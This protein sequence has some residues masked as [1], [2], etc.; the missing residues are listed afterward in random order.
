MLLIFSGV[1]GGLFAFG[2]IGLFVGPVMLAV[3]YTLLRE[4]VNDPEE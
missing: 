1:L 3:T 4:W 2:I